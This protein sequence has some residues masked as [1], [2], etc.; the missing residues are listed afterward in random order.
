MDKVV[1]FEIPA[2]D[3]ARAKRFYETAFGWAVESYP[4]FDYHGLITVQRDEKTRLPKEAGA[5][6]GGMM[7]RRSP[8]NNPV[9]TINV[10]DM[11]RA[12]EKVKKSGGKIVRE[13]MS[14]G[15]MGL[16]AYF[17]DSEGN[18]LGLWQELKK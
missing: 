12:V 14:V 13:K 18:V 16:A 6:N 4:E 3:T 7:K 17:E 10:E 2:D 9:I 5:I 15:G 11:D 8:I 1:H